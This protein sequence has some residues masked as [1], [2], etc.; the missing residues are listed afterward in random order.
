MTK[1]ED[2]CPFS[3]AS[4]TGQYKPGI[5]HRDLSSQNV[6]VRDDG[7]C[8]IGDLGLALVLPGLAQP[9]TWAPSQPRGPAAIMEAGTQRY[10]APELL[11]K[12]LD[13]QD[14]GTALRRADIYSLALLLWEIMSRCPD[15]RPGEDGGDSGPLPAPPRPLP[16][17]PT[18][19]F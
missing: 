18:C 15:L 3:L 5:A 9:P 6:L 12:T 17:C 11:D 14:W 10:M 4:P 13:L 7:S 8:A 2:P 1:E 16:P 19:S